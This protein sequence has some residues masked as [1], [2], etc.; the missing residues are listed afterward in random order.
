MAT[1]KL[2]NPPNLPAELKAKIAALHTSKP[3]DHPPAP[4]RAKKPLL[5]GRHLMRVEAELR[6]QFPGVF[7]AQPQPLAR[8][9]L[10]A[11]AFLTGDRLTWDEVAGYLGNFTQRLG[12]TMALARG[13]ERVSVTGEAAGMVAIGH[14]RAACRILARRKIMTA[15]VKALQKEIEALWE[16]GRDGDGKNPVI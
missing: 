2:T 14:R 15:E 6:R 3:A 10:E 11:L 9:T 8:G 16:K 5:R 1:L 4:N 7:R 12:Y 13:G